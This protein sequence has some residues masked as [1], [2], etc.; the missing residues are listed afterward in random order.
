MSPLRDM[1]T[2]SLLKVC[3]YYIGHMSNLQ[4]LYQRTGERCCVAGKWSS[5]SALH[6]FVAAKARLKLSV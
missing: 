2:A 6:V 4:Y 5:L 3:L 1:H